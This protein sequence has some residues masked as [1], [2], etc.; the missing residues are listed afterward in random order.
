MTCTFRK[1]QCDEKD[2]PTYTH[3]SSDSSSIHN[4]RG[5]KIIIFKKL[6]GI[7]ETFP[8]IVETFLGMFQ[9]KLFFFTGDFKTNGKGT[10]H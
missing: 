6:L 8:G 9:L 4:K 5:A 2:K 10:F 3:D 7:V 1:D